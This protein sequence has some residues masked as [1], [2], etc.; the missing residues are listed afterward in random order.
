MTRIS[1][2]HREWLNDPAYK[3]EYDALGPEFELMESLVRARTSAGLTQAEVAE[4][5]GTTQSAVAR[6][7]SGRPLPSTRTLQRYAR[8]TG[9]KL[10]IMLEVG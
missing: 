2:L 8:A 6:L 3:A 4:R 9:S 5:M 10:R 1:T 7:E